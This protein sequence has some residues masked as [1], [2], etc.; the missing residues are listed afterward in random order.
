MYDEWIDHDSANGELA[1]TRLLAAA[2]RSPEVALRR[3]LEAHGDHAGG[4]RSGRVARR[5]AGRAPRLEESPV[6]GP[7]GAAGAGTSSR[8]RSRA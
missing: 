1:V 8:Q 7:H 3:V 2:R 4:T 5:R 6:R